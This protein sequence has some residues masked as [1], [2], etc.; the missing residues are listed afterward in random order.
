MR[1]ALLEIRN[2]P[3]PFI[4]AYL[5]AAR[6]RRPNLVAQEGEARALLAQQRS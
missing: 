6:E 2:D 1:E 3:L 5:A 4:V